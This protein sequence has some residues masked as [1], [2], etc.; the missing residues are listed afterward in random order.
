MF[1]VK[2][3]VL[4]LA[5]LTALSSAEPCDNVPV[6]ILG[7]SGPCDEGCP[8]PRM[9]VP[10]E[11]SCRHIAD[12]R[13]VRDFATTWL[14]HARC[15]NPL[16]RPHRSSSHNE[17][18]RARA[19]GANMPLQDEHRG[20]VAP[21]RTVDHARRGL[22]RS[23][24]GG[25]ACRASAAPHPAPPLPANIVCPLPRRAHTHPRWFHPLFRGMTICTAGGQSCAQ[26]WTCHAHKNQHRHRRTNRCRPAHP[27]LNHP[28]AEDNVLRWCS[29]RRLGTVRQRCPRVMQGARHLDVSRETR[30]KSSRSA[31]WRPLHAID[32]ERPLPRPRSTALEET[33]LFGH[34]A[35]APSASR[36]F[37]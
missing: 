30:G 18:P 4:R 28:L 6:V 1:H 32:R 14:R 22:R 5:P 26:A 19:P 24:I 3:E 25:E 37:P 33:R 35:S 15:V 29:I 13:V 9:K 23:P 27:P 12:P 10:R 34:H 17:P 20:G 31:D 16:R 11:T 21:P 36:G 8:T 7:L 2:R